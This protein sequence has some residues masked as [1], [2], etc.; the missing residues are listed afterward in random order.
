VRLIE[1]A[2]PL[3]KLVYFQYA[4]YAG[5][6]CR[7]GGDGTSGSS[8]VG[9]MI[10]I[11]QKLCLNLAIEPELIL[12]HG[13][14]TLTPLPLRRRDLHFNDALFAHTEADEKEDAELSGLAAFAA[15]LAHRTRFTYKAPSSVLGA[16]VPAEDDNY[17][18]EYWPSP[19]S[20]EGR[21]DITAEAVKDIPCAEAFIW[22]P[23]AGQ[24]TEDRARYER[25]YKQLM[26]GRPVTEEDGAIARHIT[27]RA[28]PRDFCSTK[29]LHVLAY[30]RHDAPPEDK[31]IV[32]SSS[33]KA[34]ELLARDLREHAGLASLLISG[35]TPKEKR[36]AVLEQFAKDDSC[37]VLLLSLPLGAMGLNI[38]C[39]NHILFLHLWW[40][41][42]LEKHA[43]DRVRRIGQRKPI[44]ITHFVL[45]KTIELFVAGVAHRKRRLPEEIIDTRGKRKRKTTEQEEEGLVISHNFAHYNVEEVTAQRK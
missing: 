43:E 1:F 39:A 2:H 24:P 35:R 16:L 17:V 20:R 11:A 31:V 6:L 7:G 29:N 9:Q 15:R 33:V 28:L 10:L 5:R 41:P 3:E 26:D 25:V 22:D 19:C 44:Y 18:L 12:P 27:R 21:R 14:V 4:A 45:N 30:M 8:S 40:N 42:E 38:V 34:L 32:F 13:M 37:R 36:T 23:F